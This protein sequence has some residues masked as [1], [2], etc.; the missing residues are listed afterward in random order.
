MKGRK[1]HEKKKELSERKEQFKNEKTDKKNYLKKCDTMCYLI[2][3]FVGATGTIPRNMEKKL[4][5]L[6]E[7]AKP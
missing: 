4:G 6:E 7:E 5:E 3:I 1:M 2:P